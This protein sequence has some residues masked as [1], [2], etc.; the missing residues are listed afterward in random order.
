MAS[1]GSTCTRARASPSPPLMNLCTRP[2]GTTTVSPAF[3]TMV[4]IPRRNFIVPSRTS[5]R[6]SCSG[7]TWAPGTRPSAAR[8]SSNSSS[9]PFVSVAVCRNSMRSPLTGFSMI[10]PA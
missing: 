5:K 8:V 7:W 4:R 10:C 2:A 6:S 3:A 1:A 9:S